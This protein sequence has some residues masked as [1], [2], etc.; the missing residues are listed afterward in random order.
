[1][2]SGQWQFETLPRPYY[3]Y[4]YLFTSPNSEVVERMTFERCNK[5][6]ANWEKKNDVRTSALQH[7]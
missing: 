1:M 4:A 2:P 6:R 3:S 7:D 5:S